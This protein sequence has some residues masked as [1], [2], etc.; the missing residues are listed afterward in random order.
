MCKKWTCLTLIILVLVLA[1]DTPAELMVQWNLDEGSGT[2]VS[3][4]SGNGRDGIFNGEPQWVAGHNSAGALH[5]DGVDD[6]V[7]HDLGQTE[8]FPTFSVA[9]WVKADTLGQPVYASPFTGHYPNSAGFQVDVDGGNPGNYRINPNSGNQFAF[10]PV[11]LDWVHL[12]LTGEGTSMNLY[13]NGELAGS[14]TLVDTDVVFNQFAIG[15]NRNRNWWFAC[16]IDDLRV[17]DH[18]LSEAEILGTLSLIHI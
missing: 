18:I 7:V 8:T 16:T 4:T 5:F 13:Y 6:F 9:F 3:D 17:Y 14:N 12:A 11:T 2:I 15:V 10:G 1:A